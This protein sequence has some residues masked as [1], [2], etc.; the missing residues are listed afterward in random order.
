MKQHALILFWVAEANL[1]LWLMV[2]GSVIGIKQAD[3][4]DMLMH[5]K[6]FCYAGVFLAAL[7]Q[8]WAYYKIYKPAKEKKK[9]NKALQATSL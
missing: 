9:Q 8:H 6:Y 7:L 1:I 2:V 5:H 3:D 4:A